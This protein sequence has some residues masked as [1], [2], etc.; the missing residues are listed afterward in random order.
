MPLRLTY[1]QPSPIPVEVQGLTPDWARTRTLAEVE[2]F[3]IHHGNQTVPLAELFDIEGDSAD[4]VIEWVGDLRGVHWIGAEMTSGRIV[5]E[6][7]A[8]RHLGS[9]MSGGE[10]HVRGDVGDFCGVEMHRGQIRVDGSAGDLLGGAYRGSPKGMTGGT[11]L[12][13][14]DAG[15]ETG[16]TMRR[17]LIAV[18]GAAGDLTGCNMIAGTILVFGACGIRPGAGMRRGTIGLLGSSAPRLLPSFRRGAT[19]Q[20]QFLSLWL[21]RLKDLG[22]EA[23]SKLSRTEIDLYHGDLVST[24]KGE[25]LVRASAVLS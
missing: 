3:P 7:S 16:H 24:G 18:G 6:G 25:I 11:I 5:I 15:H 9:Q 20:P 13:R 19:F 8:G 23:A 1:R 10:I 14:G 12:V 4:G 17:G 2:R 21:K 22:F